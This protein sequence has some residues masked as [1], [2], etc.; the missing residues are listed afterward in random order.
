MAISGLEL[1]ESR[2][3]VRLAGAVRAR[4]FQAIPAP[5][6]YTCTPEYVASVHPDELQ[7][8]LSRTGVIKRGI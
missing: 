1:R 3:E 7:V 6:I 8:G 5:E 4:A 2:V